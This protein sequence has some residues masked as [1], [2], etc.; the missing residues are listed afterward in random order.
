MKKFKSFKFQLLPKSKHDLIMRRFA[1]CCRFVWNRAL[2][3]EKEAFETDGKRIGYTRLSGLLPIWKK[4]QETAFLAESN[5]QILQQTLKDLD[6][7]YQNFFAKRAELP[8][9]KK[10]GRTNS[11]RFPQGFKLDEGNRR[12]YLP[13]IG[14]IKY[15]QSRKIEGIAKQV[16][17]SWKAGHWYIFIQTEQDIPQPIHP[18]PAAIIGIDLGVTRFAT[19]SDGTV[20]EPVHAFKNH[21]TKLARLQRILSKKKRFSSNWRKQ[22]SRIQRLHRK[23]AHV[24]ADFLHKATTTISKNHATVVLEN[25]KVSNMS[26]SASGTLDK[27]GE[28]V[29]AKSGLNKSILDQGWS[30]FRRQIEYKEIWSGGRLILVSAKYTSQTCHQCGHTAKGNRLSPASFRCTRCG[31]AANAAYNAALNILAAGQAVS[32][33]GAGKPAGKQEPTL[34]LLERTS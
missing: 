5:A 28:N 26:R 2:A 27:P 14:W 4:E 31:Y 3:L 34:N 23:I 17:V 33:C 7:A 10:K 29:R 16:S 1:G 6:Q 9:F 19:L 15:R 21:V 30:E 25:L 11:F 32:A 8:K 20:I 12:I 24:R 13:K 18:L 22:Q